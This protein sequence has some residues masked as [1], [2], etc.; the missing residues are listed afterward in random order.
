METI[1]QFCARH[2]YSGF[3]KSL[4]GKTVH[5]K[6]IIERGY[7][8]GSYV[9]NFQNLLKHINVTQAEAHAHF[10]DIILKTPYED[11]QMEIVKFVQAKGK[12]DIIQSYNI[13]EYMINKKPN[14]FVKYLQQMK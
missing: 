5:A 12:Y 10:K 2:S 6:E 7:G 11:I 4:G 8:Y 14:I 3:V 9:S 1:N 13:V